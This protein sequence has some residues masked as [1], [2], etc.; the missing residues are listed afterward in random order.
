MSNISNISTLLTN[1]N[2]YYPIVTTDNHGFTNSKNIYNTH[3][4]IMLIG[5][6]YIEGYSVKSE[7]SI[8]SNL[9]AAGFNTISLGKGGNG[10][11][12]ELAS[13]REYAKPYKP[14]IVIWFFVHNDFR[15][16]HYELRSDLLTNYLIDV[17]FGQDL[18]NK[19]SEIDNF[20]KSYINSEK[21]ELKQNKLN[22]FNLDK[23]IEVFKLSQLRIYF[24]NTLIYSNTQ[25]NYEILHKVLMSANN[26]VTSWGGEFYFVYIPSSQTIKNSLPGNSNISFNKYEGIS[27]IED[28][29][30]ICKKLNIEVIDFFSEINK[31]KNYKTIFP[32][33]SAGHYNKKG[34]KLLSDKLIKKL[35]LKDE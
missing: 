24:I 21:E 18:I 17:N 35:K 27:T 28:I 20:I 15:N 22:F 31:I 14:S 1:E 7:N 33:E 34:Y 2:G 16:L 13:L 12:I 10:P 25:K 4:D 32:L 11:I 3:I 8:G 9:N 30:E 19:Q 5:D 23:I 6:S 26:E 29:H